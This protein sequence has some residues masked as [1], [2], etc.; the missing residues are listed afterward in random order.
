MDITTHSIVTAIVYFNFF[1]GIFSLVRR[2]D[3]IILYF[4]IAPLVYLC[5]LAIVRILCM[6]EFPFTRV[7]VLENMNWIY[8]KLKI[9]IRLGKYEITIGLFLCAIWGIGA[10]IKLFHFIS[11]MILDQRDLKGVEWITDLDKMSLCR[12][13]THKQTHMA[14]TEDQIPYIVGFFQPIIF[15]PNRLLS[16]NELKYILMHEWQHF[17]SKDQWKKTAIKILSCLV[18]WNPFIHLLRF[19]IEQTLELSC[20]QKVLKQLATEEEQIAYLEVIKD[21][22]NLKCKSHEA[23]KSLA[24]SIV[25]LFHRKYLY[26]PFRLLR[27]RLLLGMEYKVSSSSRKVRSVILCI[28]ITFAFVAS[29]LANFQSRYQPSKDGGISRFPEGTILKER[30]DGTYTIVVDGQ[31]WANLEDCDKEP[32]ASMP[33]IPFEK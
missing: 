6:V 22:S 28:A 16:D 7:I 26:N 30:R 27:Q 24:S 13:V 12:Q 10:A 32:F 5:L 29:Y 14:F 11:Q 15:L 2:K 18:W 25:P 20:D 21:F 31:E 8:D 1:I 3:H 9:P 4:G 19:E 23:D 17:K 33:I